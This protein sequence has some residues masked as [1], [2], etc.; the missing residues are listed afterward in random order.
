MILVV[1]QGALRIHYSSINRFGDD[2]R[3]GLPKIST[4]EFPHLFIMAF[5]DVPDPRIVSV[6]RNQEVSQRFHVPF[7]ASELRRVFENRLYAAS[8]VAEAVKVRGIRDEVIKRG[9]TPVDNW[10]SCPCGTDG[11]LRLFSEHIVIC[12]S[13]GYAFADFGYGPGGVQP[14]EEV[15][16]GVFKDILTGAPRASV[17]LSTEPTNPTATFDYLAAYRFSDDQNL[18]DMPPYNGLW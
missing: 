6:H 15:E 17:W 2:P 10:R 8:S 1:A 9:D 13:C 14:K 5:I 16:P 11:S 3:T 18:L 12:E 7:K 4:K